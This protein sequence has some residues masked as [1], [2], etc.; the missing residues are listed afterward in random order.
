[1]SAAQSLQARACFPFGDLPEAFLKCL[2]SSCLQLDDVA[3][4]ACVSKQLLKLYRERCAE[5]ERFLESAAITAFGNQLAELVSDWAACEVDGPPAYTSGRW[6]QKSPVVEVDLTRGD[7]LP[8][9]EDLHGK[10]SIR[11]IVPP[12]EH[13]E[14]PQ[15]DAP[16]EVKLV[17]GRFLR[18]VYVIDSSATTHLVSS[19]FKQSDGQAIGKV[20]FRVPSGASSTSICVTGLV[21]MIC[22]RVGARL[23]AARDN[24]AAS[25]VPIPKLVR[26]MEIFLRS[27]NLVQRNLDKEVEDAFKT[28][29]AVVGR[30][31]IQLRRDVT[32]IME[33]PCEE[34]GA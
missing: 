11:F 10:N 34:V 26:D 20:H 29:R 4:A 32:G 13:S 27:S 30:I 7:T 3:R 22:N 8:R 2:L 16:C 6:V 15:Q 31:R 19:G 25:R 23:A 12:W 33:G 21:V 1:V 18:L 17:I 5:E 14:P 28:L 9:F 24:D